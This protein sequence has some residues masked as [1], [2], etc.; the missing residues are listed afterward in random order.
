MKNFDMFGAM[1]DFSRN[2]VATVDYLKKFFPLLKK[3]GYNSIFMYTEDTYEVEGEPFF[4]YMRGR[5]S[6]EELKELDEY[7]KSIGIELIPCVQ[8]LAHLE[9][10]I[11]WK[12]V[13]RDDEF[14]ILA[15]DERTYEFIDNMFASLA[16]AYTTRKV[17]VG[18]DEA[19]NLGRGTHMNK[20]GLE[21]PIKIIKRHLN[22]VCELAK[23]H[24]FEPVLLWSDMFFRDWNNGE[25]H[26]PRREM[27]QE[28]KEALPSGAVPVYWDYYHTS[29]D[30][31]CTMLD[32]HHDLSKDTWFA[33]GAWCWNGFVPHNYYALKTLSASIDACIDKGV[34]NYMV[35]VWRD[36]GEGT[37]HSVLP[38]M[39]YAAER[40]KGNKDEKSIKEKFK[41]IIGIDFDD[42]ML[43]DEPNN[44]AGNEKE[45]ENP[46][47]P[48]RY[49]FY[50]DCLLG[51]ADYTVKEGAGKKY[52]EISGKLKEVSKKSR[53]Y[54]YIFKTAAELC[55]VLELKYDLGVRTRKAY[56]SKNKDELLSLVNNEYAK[57]PKLIDKFATTYEK[58]WMTENKCQGL[59]VMSTRFG[60]VIRRIEFV[61]RRL[62]DYCNGKLDR[63][64][65]L[66]CEILP[67]GEKE[68]STDV[69]WYSEMTTC[70]YVK[71]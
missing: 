39:F 49:M 68:E 42:Y 36:G 60:G 38:S 1:L 8:T 54:G 41:K 16:K 24:G 35:T 66:E 47:N 57:L 45:A 31:Y 63:I 59:E 4:G 48:S 19:I 67:Y 2:G 20:F 52:A 21:P 71:I 70:G 13:P 25:Y 7:A 37:L 65:E 22:R 58:Q 17:H 3:M 40:A 43:L 62:L 64:E 56:Q 14:I 26:I 9:T 15:D 50:S 33:G 51:F 30:Y 11:R 69:I 27:P 12:K 46:R 10:F 18:L 53:K 6:I 32:N 55:D 23:K 61:R 28:Y 29:Y 44:I 5:Y 34:R